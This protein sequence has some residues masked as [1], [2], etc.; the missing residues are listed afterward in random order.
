MR[1]LGIGATVHGKDGLGELG[2]LTRFGPAVARAW[3]G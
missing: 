1:M 3:Q 2:K